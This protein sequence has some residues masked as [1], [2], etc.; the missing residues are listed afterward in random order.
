MGVR[1][2]IRYLVL[3]RLSG[4]SAALRALEL[5]FVQ[6]MS[7]SDVAHALG[8]S[9]NSVRGYIRRA[10]EKYP[11]AAAVISAVIRYAMPLVLSIAPAIEANRPAGVRCRI[12]GSLAATP[13]AGYFHIAVAHRDA[14]ESAVESIVKSIVRS[15]A[16]AVSGAR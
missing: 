12:C 5:Y 1:D 11:S 3:L 7:P 13:G 9:K 2:L 6:K 16:Q 10:I 14:V 15:V 8:I 4:N